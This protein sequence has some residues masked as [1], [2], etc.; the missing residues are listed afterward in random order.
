MDLDRFR[1]DRQGKVHLSDHPTRLASAPKKAELMEMVERDRERIGELQERLYAQ[2]TQALLLIFQAMDAAG[3]DSCIAHVLRGV[4]PQGCRAWSFKAPSVEELSHDFLWRHAHAVPARGMIGVHNRSH[5]EEVLVV[6]VHP[7]YLL[8]QRL[9]EI[10]TVAQADTAFWKHRY[11]SIR[12]FEEHLVSQ[13]VV[14]MKFF[15]HL[16]KASQKERFLERM[17][18]PEKSWKFS[19][20]DLKERALWN[21]YEEA[22]QEAINATAAPH[23]PWH[24]VPADEQW[25]SRAIVSA[26]VRTGM[27]LPPVVVGLALYLLL[28][29]SGP[30]GRLGW[31]FTPQAMVLAQVVLTLPFVVGITAASVEAVPPDL[32][33]LGP[34]RRRAWRAA[35]REALEGRLAEGATVSGFL[36]RPDRY[37]VEGP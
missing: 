4:S 20:G 30:L 9:P 17:D 13:G 1:V 24:I 27:A 5:Y 22:Y 36:R 6:K 33:G 28:S 19:L 23:A 15:L 3:K 37:L 7:E 26:L 31:L 11:A 29:R 14:I 25:E 8:A 16:G 35:V 12:Q 21:E 34:D 10:R 2:G 18:D 32:E